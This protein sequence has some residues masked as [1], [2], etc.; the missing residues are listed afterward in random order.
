MRT[1][2]LFI[3]HSWG[4]SDSYEKLVNLLNSRNYFRFRNYSV[5]HDDPVHGAGTNAQLRQ[6]IRNQ[7][8]PVGVVL[9]LAGVYATYSKWINIEIDLAERGFNQPKPII[10][11]EPW[12]SEKTS[13]RVKQAAD[14]IV[15]WNTESIVNAIRELA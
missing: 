13:V 10:A 3:S 7:M 9:I 4:Y 15:K 14:R 8:A 5:P 1:H 6:A 12:G 2:H 11:I